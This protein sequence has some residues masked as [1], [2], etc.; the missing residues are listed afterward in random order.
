MYSPRFLTVLSIFQLLTLLASPAS[1]RNLFFLVNVKS[2]VEIGLS[3]ILVQISDKRH[4]VHRRFCWVW[5]WLKRFSLSNED[6]IKLH[7]RLF[8]VNTFPSVHQQKIFVDPLALQDHPPVFVFRFHCT[9]SHLFSSSTSLDFIYICYREYFKYT[10]STSFS[11][12]ACRTS[13]LL[14]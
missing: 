12:C 3:V 2:D 1:M 10:I 5:E 7:I 6:N 4:M 9:L 11:N 14:T 8:L 13:V